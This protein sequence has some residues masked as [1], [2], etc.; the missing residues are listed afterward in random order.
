MNVESKEQSNEIQ[1]QKE[2]YVSSSLVLAHTAP[3]FLRNCIAT[4]LHVRA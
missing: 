2:N 1:H 3:T 4:Y